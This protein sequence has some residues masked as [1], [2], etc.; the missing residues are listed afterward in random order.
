MDDV[1]YEPVPHD[2]AAFLAEASAKEGFL[3]AYESLRAEY[4]IAHELLRARSRAQLTQAA[5]AERMG[6]TKSAVSRLESVGKHSPSIATLRRYAEATGCSLQIRLVR[7]RT[8]APAQSPGRSDQHGL[9]ESKA[10]LRRT[11][12]A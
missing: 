10:R 5:V 3:E 2:H 6:T 9:T 8:D 4:E 11:V 7:T 12:Q 1:K